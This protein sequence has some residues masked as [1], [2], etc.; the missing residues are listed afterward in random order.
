MKV[1]LYALL[2]ILCTSF[3]N[4]AH[5]QNTNKIAGEYD[6]SL[7][8]FEDNTYIRA[9]SHGIE[10]GT[11]DVSG[12]HITFNHYKQKHDFALYGRE[13]IGRLYGN[14]IMFQGFDYD[15]LVNL[16]E[17][18]NPPK[19]MRRVF[20]RGVNCVKWPTVYDNSEIDSKD[21]YF[22]AIN[23]SVLYKFE[24]PKGFRDFVAFRYSDNR[25][26][27]YS[28]PT[29]IISEDFSSLSFYGKEDKMI[30]KPLTKEMLETKE[31][32]VSLYEK[33]YPEG[34]YYYCNPSYNIFEESTIDISDYTEFGNRNEGVFRLKGSQS[35]AP[36]Y[37]H[38][39]D[40]NF[41]SKEII[42]RYTR[43][44]PQV[45]SKME[46]SIDDNSI[47]TFNCDIIE[48]DVL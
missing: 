3:S 31:L 46:Y 5:A 6:D 17:N 48:V 14:T 33:A 21:I 43:I 7:F 37:E 30:K 41:H 22:T 44:E 8:I 4:C 2:T 40:F 47:F 11:V 29:A 23:D 24:L 25:N 36:L 19:V 27:Y 9:E 20:N 39:L 38:R 35:D 10:F 32:I 18:N 42:Y 13:V 28:S 1:L 26:P 15:G 34:E 12:D 16:S 45:I